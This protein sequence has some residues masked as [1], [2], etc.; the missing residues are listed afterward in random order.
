MPLQIHNLLSAMQLW[1]TRPVGF[2]LIWT[3]MTVA[4]AIFT[5]CAIRPASAPDIPRTTKGFYNLLITRQLRTRGAVA[6]VTLLAFFLVFYMA[7]TLLWDDFVFNDSEFFTLGTLVGHNI[8]PPIWPGEGRFFPLALQEFNFARHFTATTTGYHLI[9]IIQ[10]LAFTYIVLVT[11]D[12]LPVEAR[13]TLAILILLT[14]SVWASFTGLTNSERNVLFFLS[15][16]VLSIKRF[17]QTKLSIWAIIATISAQAMLYYKETSFLLIFGLAIGRLVLRCRNER[18]AGWDYNRLWDKEGRLDL[19]LAMLAVLFVLYYLGVIGFHRTHYADVRQMP[20]VEILLAFLRIDL[21]S[22]LFSVVVLARIYMILRR[23]A[24]PDPLWDG[25]AVGG[26]V[27]FLAY[28]CFRIFSI[29]YLA[30]VDLIAILYV[31]QLT[32]LSWKRLGPW[33]HAA[34]WV[35]ACIVVLQD[36]SL[37]AVVTFA[38]KNGVHGD[39]QIA[40]VIEAQHRHNSRNVLRLFFPFARPYAIME[41]A[42]YLNY[43]GVPMEGAPG[44]ATGPKSMVLA[45][46]ATDEEGPCVEQESIRCHAASGPDPDDLVIV[47]PDDEASFAE[48]AVYRERGAALLAYEPRPSIPE[49]LHPAILRIA[50]FAN[51]NNKPLPDRWMHGFVTVW[52]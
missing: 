22:W 34:A 25:L 24:V 11:D 46:R 30:P 37:S 39:V 47:L 32:V 33:C 40:R 44:E 10:L 20:Q 36:V 15:C 13:G 28:N 3:T 49:W 29:Y 14:P 50:S 48:T 5:V 45:R 52:K 18:D 12:A 35:L 43:L 42:A 2:L 1:V 4:M 7:M 9:P 8:S 21:L 38:H 26:L 16:L 41:F 51:G 6:T 17:G 27:V 23:R 31:G 19:C